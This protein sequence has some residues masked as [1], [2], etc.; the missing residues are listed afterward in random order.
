[1]V[2]GSLVRAPRFTLPG[3]NLTGDCGDRKSLLVGCGRG[4]RSEC[5]CIC[6]ER[7]VHPV[8]A[9]R[10]SVVMVFAAREARAEQWGGGQEERRGEQMR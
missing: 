9:C 1:M 5:A 6:G 4:G 2:L 3:H 7:S 8:I 10:G